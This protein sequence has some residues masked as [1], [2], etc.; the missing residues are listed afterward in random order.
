M[1]L[2]SRLKLVDVNDDVSRCAVADASSRLVLTPVVDGVEDNTNESWVASDCLVV[3]QPYV[4]GASILLDF[5]EWVLCVLLHHGRTSCLRVHLQLLC[6]VVE[7]VFP[8]QFL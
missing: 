3:H 4:D 7:Y 5:V 1:S 2:L 6:T 8:F